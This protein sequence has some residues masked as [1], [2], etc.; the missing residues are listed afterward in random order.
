MRIASLL[1][2]AT[3][4]VC[5]VGAR[6][7][8]VGISHECDYPS[9][10]AGLPILTRTRKKLPRASGDIDRAVREILMDAVAVYE[11]EVERMAAA[12][13]DVI[14]TQDLC[15]IC[16]VSID[17]VRRVISELARQDVEIVSL[18]PT[19]LGD[20]WADVRRVG[21]ALGREEEGI[22]AAAGMME[23]IEAIGKRSKAIAGPRPR[24]APTREV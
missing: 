22:E 11:I 5:A 3:E 19:N 12:K 7:E 21:R 9:G 6:D 20:V 8:L 24:D 23:C 18:K 15:D 16:A 17:D 10:L 14:V 4:M 13:P 2:S 1:L